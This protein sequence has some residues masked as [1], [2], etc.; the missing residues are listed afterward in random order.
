MHRF[1]HWRVRIQDAIDERAIVNVIREYRLTLTIEMLKLLP[2]DCRK[3]LE[4]ND[5]QDTALRCL[6]AE[7]RSHDTPELMA[8]LHEVAQTYAAA[9]L[10]VKGWRAASR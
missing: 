7:M 5:I 4:G 10:R 8:L 2:E 6:Q 9:A 3:A 1:H